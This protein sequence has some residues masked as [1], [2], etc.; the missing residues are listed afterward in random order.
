MQLLK[1]KIR[2]PKTSTT[3]V[4]PLQVAGVCAVQADAPSDTPGRWASEWSRALQAGDEATAT[5]SHVEE[6]V[7]L[8]GDPV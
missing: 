5:G 8:G 3:H 1:H 2:A 6:G 7:R 4:K